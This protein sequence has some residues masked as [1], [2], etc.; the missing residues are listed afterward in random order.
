MVNTLNELLRIENL[1]VCVVLKS[2]RDLR[3][4]W[5][6]TFVAERV[7]CEVGNKTEKAIHVYSIFVNNKSLVAHFLEKDVDAMVHELHLNNKQKV[8][9]TEG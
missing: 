6:D 5:T 4:S 2:G 7:D 8:T 9:V 3:F 1:D